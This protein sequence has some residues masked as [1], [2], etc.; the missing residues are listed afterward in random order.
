[1]WTVGKLAL[2][3]DAAESRRQSAFLYRLRQNLQRS[4]LSLT[5]SFAT[6]QCQVGW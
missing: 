5:R 2:G 1:M 4:T 6:P 3:G